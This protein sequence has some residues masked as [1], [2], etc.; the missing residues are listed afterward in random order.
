MTEQSAF[1]RMV[2]AVI[3]T[4]RL[5][6]LLAEDELGPIFQARN[7]V[8]NAPCRFRLLPTRGLLG[9]EDS[10]AYVQDYARRIAT[11][12]HPYIL[13]LLDFGLFRGMPYLVWPHVAMRPVS[14]RI[15]QSGPMD[16]VTTGR[17]I[18]QIAA[19]LEHAHEHE[20]LHLNLT[21]GNV[22]IQLDGQLIVADFGVRH[23]FEITA[24]SQQ[25]Q[26]L[27]GMN[28]ACAPEQ[29]LGRSVGVFTDVY[30]LGALAVRLL[31]ARPVFAGRTKDDVSQQHVYVQVPDISTW[32]RG[33]PASVAGV[34]ASALAKD[35]EQRYQQAGAFANAYHSA[36]GAPGANRLPFV[37]TPNGETASIRVRGPSHMQAATLL[38]APE[39]LDSRLATPNWEDAAPDARPSHRRT[40]ARP[41]QPSRVARRG[42]GGIVRV[43]ALVGL[44]LALVAGGLFIL[45]S[46]RQGLAGNATVTGT[47]VF[48]DGPGAAQGQS[49]LA[50]VTI[51]GADTP[52]AGQHYAAWII[53]VATESV[54]P[55]GALTAQSGGG[56]AVSGPGSLSAKNLLSA[57]NKVIVTLENGS[58][59]VPVGT[60]VATATF[61]SHSFLHI[62]HL[63]VS[64]PSTPMQSALLVG[65][66]NQTQQLDAQ[67]TQLR[68]AMASGNVS[69]ERCIFQSMID[70]M[71]GA[72]GAHYL[73]LSQECI[74]LNVTLEG[75]GFG[76]L[77]VEPVQK[78]P[79]Y[80]DAAAEHASL[81]AQQ[82]DATPAIR[83][84]APHVATAISNVKGW[85]TTL[86]SDVVR[87]LANP[88]DA[89][90]AAEVATLSDQAYR[91]IPD[92][93]DG[94]V[95]PNTGKAGAITAYDHGQYMAT[96]QLSP[97]SS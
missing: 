9:Q 11:L 83:Q 62:Q 1:V 87:L 96:L 29:V 63:L 36:I 53:D 42:V 76:L 72:H 48:L 28:D 67:A 57:G 50:R 17:Y 26:E 4:Y 6:Q 91:G 3:G 77:G 79:G 5:E 60:V 33:L 45:S 52:S 70:I 20:V 81:A 68:N 75:D 54:T 2:G 18:D 66:L 30:A 95:G 80:L 23:L 51:H 27:I 55:L 64:F 49:N 35:P 32:R 84:H 86:D 90:L 25:A 93:P 16:V 24:T 37:A 8:S 39:T 94:S 13:P 85:V 97:P 34:I 19:A 12:R 14:A 71:E 82:P 78:Y 74:A 59:T 56:F 22:H 58:S 47:V 89:N 46:G 10:A 15:L 65:M 38:P 92:N 43:A 41:A 21:T 7:N 44:V 61:P 88:T 73:P 69:L 40:G 31:T